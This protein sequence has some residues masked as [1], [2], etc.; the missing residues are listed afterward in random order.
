[1]STNSD[2]A[3]F[4]YSAVYAF[5]SLCAFGVLFAVSGEQNELSIEQF[6]GFMKKNPFLAVVLIISMLSLAG[7]PPLAGF[8]GKYYLFTTAMEANLVWLVV[9]AVIGSA[10]SIYYYFKLIISTVKSDEFLVMPHAD[11]P[12]LHQGSSPVDPPG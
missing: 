10:I 7:I 11:T 9:A 3:I 5:A 2:N 6:N 4:Y 8:L 12:L 1:M